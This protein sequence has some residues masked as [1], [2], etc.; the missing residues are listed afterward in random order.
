MQY[1]IIIYIYIYNVYYNGHSKKLGSNSSVG[2]EI[3]LSLVSLWVFLDRGRTPKSFKDIRDFNKEDI[4]KRNQNQQIK[5]LLLN[6]YIKKNV[7]SFYE[8]ITNIIREKFVKNIR[9]SDQIN[10]FYLIESVVL[11]DAYVWVRKLE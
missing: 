1:L 9:E 7:R 10:F 3:N 4:R 2:E 11:S 5:I 6:S 8:Y